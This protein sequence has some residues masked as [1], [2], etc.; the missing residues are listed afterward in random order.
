[1][2]AT[3]AADLAIDRLDPQ[4]AERVPVHGGSW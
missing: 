2:H 3:E 4:L 1:V